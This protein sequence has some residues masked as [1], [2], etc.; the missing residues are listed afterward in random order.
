MKNRFLGLTI[1]SLA[2]LFYF[3]EM[4][5]R[6][7]L[8][9]IA[10]DVIH[11]LHLTA[12]QFSTI[13]AAYFI[14]YG[15]LQL[16]VGLISERLGPRLTLSISC[17]L[18]TIGVFLFSIA[19][20]FW[21]AFFARLLI[22]FGSAFAFVSLLFLTLKWFPREHFS[23]ISGIA[24]FLGAVAPVLAGGPL[25]L[26]YHSLDD[27]WR[28]IMGGLTIFGIALSICLLLFIQSKPNSQGGG[29][30]FL[31][32]REKVH[33]LVIA[34]LKIP[35]V[36][37]TLLYSAFTYVM[38]AL[39]SA[40]WGTIF[41]QARGISLT[42]SAT[43]VSAIWIGYAVTSP[44]FGKLSDRIK[45]RKPFLMYPALFSALISAALLY[46]PIYSP[47][48]LG[49]LFFLIGAGVGGQSLTYAVILE[50]VPRKLHSGALGINNGATT[51][52]P[53]VIPV[54]AG[55][56]IQMNSTGK[57][58]TETA[59]A[60]GLCVAPICFFLAFLVSLFFMKETFCRQQYEMHTLHKFSDILD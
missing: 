6:I 22:G 46:L 15:C 50:H 7:C 37:V 52:S 24:I 13:G 44:L 30:I 60:K 48:V 9:T 57:D 59:L 54:L 17:L 58:F 45:R 51:L 11:D 38:L 14:T 31:Q 26:L 29:I 10:E 55:A 40:Y 8:G 21:L 41:L 20:D 28:I 18:C 34:L 39:F 53:A 32:F 56:I 5:L 23:L 47:W 25:A 4:F 33:T 35:Q 12:G 42:L 43:V 36:W 19:I 1:W 16:F 2:L 3:F 49:A 27:N